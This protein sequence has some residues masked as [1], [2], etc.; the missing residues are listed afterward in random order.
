[1]VEGFSIGETGYTLPTRINQNDI[2]IRRCRFYQAQ[3]TAGYVYVDSNNVVVEQCYFDRVAPILVVRG[4]ADIVR[5]CYIGNCVTLEPN[6][7][8]QSVYNN[9]LFWIDIVGGAAFNNIVIEGMSVR[10]TEYDLY[11]NVFV[12]PES[13]HGINNISNF[14][15]SSLFVGGTHPE[16][17][18]RLAISSP[19]IGAGYGG[20]DCGMFAGVNPYLNSGM[21]PIPS[22]SNYSSPAHATPTSGLSVTIEA[23]AHP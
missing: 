20:V 15:E 10:A 6:G 22:I 18:Y 9:V 8:V 11:N 3:Y 23:T 4:N 13:G 1:M 2:I 7:T 17:K 5:N 16:N 19:A 12:F 21:P 14:T